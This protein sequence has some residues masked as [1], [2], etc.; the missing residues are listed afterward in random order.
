MILYLLLFYII[1]IR[2]YTNIRNNRNS[3]FELI[4]MMFG[5]FVVIAFRDENSGTDT[6]NY[7]ANFIRIKSYSFATLSQASSQEFGF[8]LFEWILGKAFPNCNQALFIAQALIV[9]ISNGFFIYKY[10]NKNYFLAVLGFMTFGLFGFHITGVRQSLAMSFCI[11]AYYLYDKKGYILG[12]LIVLL[13]CT[14]HLSAVVA[15]L[16]LFYGKIWRFGNNI[17]TTM[18]VGIIVA[19]T[20]GTILSKVSMFTDRWNSYSSIES[21]GNGQIFM[22]VLLIIVVLGET[23]PYH[24]KEFQYAKRINYLSLIF[25]MGRLVTRTM[26]R[27]ALYFFPAN[28]Q[29]MV[30][31][32]EN[33]KYKENRKLLKIGAFICI[34]L[35]YLYRFKGYNYHLIGIF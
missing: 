27:P 20:S 23:L 33:N 30:N 26:Q 2:V 19:T 28:L 12:T 13:A 16:Y 31:G 17:L 9:S 5:V 32:I 6:W 25:W 8:V 24:N 22:M 10:C 11:W 1:A 29:I 3:L 18:V 7:L 4:L 21:T 14:F 34:S 35:Y 15:I